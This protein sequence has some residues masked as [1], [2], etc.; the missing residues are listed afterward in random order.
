MI[1]R[2]FVFS[3]E[4]SIIECYLIRH[5]VDHDDAMCASV[6]GGGDGAKTLLPGRVPLVR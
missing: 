2:S 3:F 1:A 4:I 6:V 5:V